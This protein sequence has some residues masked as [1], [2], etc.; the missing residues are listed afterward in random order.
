METIKGKKKEVATSILDEK[1]NVEEDLERIKA[2]YQKHFES[3]LKDRELEGKRKL[4][5]S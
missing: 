2:L 5:S 1:G 4:A 3:L